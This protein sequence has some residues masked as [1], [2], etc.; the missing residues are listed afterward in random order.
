M[1]TQ[2]NIDALKLK[3]KHTAL[4]ELLRTHY[5]VFMHLDSR[6]DNVIVPSDLR[7]PQLT[8][9]LGLNLQPNPIADMKIDAKGFSATLS[10]NRQATVV[11]VPWSAVYAI[12]GD[13]GIGNVWHVDVPP[14][15]NPPK[16]NETFEDKT[17]PVQRDPELHKK[18]PPGWRVLDGGKKIRV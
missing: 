17:I 18:L 1:H 4:Q 13:S 6:R 7:R 5:S 14:E 2:R 10:F 8:L 3:A 9:K 15:V 16:R 11:F 12:V